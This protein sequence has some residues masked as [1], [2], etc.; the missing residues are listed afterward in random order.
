MSLYPVTLAQPHGVDASPR[1]LGVTLPS[2]I[3]PTGRARL[4]ARASPGWGLGSPPSWL[5]APGGPAFE[6]LH[7]L[8]LQ[9]KVPWPPELLE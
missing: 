5:W 3:G 4:G 6:P 7:S 9:D 2:C 8:R 1:L